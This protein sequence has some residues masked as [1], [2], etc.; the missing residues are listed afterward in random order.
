VNPLPVGSAFG[1]DAVD[2]RNPCIASANG[3]FV[4]VWERNDTAADR[5]LWFSRTTGSGGPQWS[6]PARI[7][8]SSATDTGSDTHPRITTDGAGHWVVVYES[9]ENHFATGTDVE[10]YAYRSS[11][12]GLTWAGPALVNATASSDAGA[13]DTEPAVAVDIATGTWMC[14]WRTLNTFAGNTG[15]D[16][17]I[18]Y[19][20]SVDLGST[21][22]AVGIVNT[23]FATDQA[24]STGDLEPFIS[25]DQHGHFMVSWTR[26]LIN[27]SDTDLRAARSDDLGATWTTPQ[28]IDIDA[29]PDGGTDS[30]SQL[31]ADNDGHWVAV[32][33][34][35]DNVSPSYGFDLDVMA[36][37]FMIPRG[38]DDANFC[39]GYTE[40]GNAARCPCGNDSIITSHSGCLN[41]SGN[42]G[43][44]GMAGP[45]S[46]SAPTQGISVSGVPSGA[47]VLFFQGTGIFG[48]GLGTPFGDGLLCAGATIDR[49]GVIF[50]NV[51]GNGSLTFAPVGVSS[52]A[53]RFYQGW[54]RDSATFCTSATFNLTSAFGTVWAP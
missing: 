7:D 15:G 49:L 26:S 37:R 19:S 41:S 30:G 48:F 18:V 14:A 25:A 16:A 24:T 10:I 2:D 9:N 44:V 17:E 42:G 35:N 13:N 54:Y 20:K 28:F 50:T 32:W 47:P 36:S 38:D 12:D 3:T 6:T 39:F 5:D 45:Y 53:T 21:W 51:N 46:A 40:V 29:T 1:A 52:G 31:V 23:D 27:D 8:P 33:Q 11:D 22:S 43:S 4:T 34:S